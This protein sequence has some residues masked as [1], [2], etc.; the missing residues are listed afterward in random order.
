[1]P[2]FTAELQLSISAD[3]AEDADLLA[4]LVCENATNEFGS[5]A[6]RRVPG[7]LAEATVEAVAD[8]AN[9]RSLA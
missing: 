5:Y 9:S 7:V 3:S 1:M 2:M 8:R 4:T 6:P